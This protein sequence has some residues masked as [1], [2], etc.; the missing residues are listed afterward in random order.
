LAKK[1]K[2]KICL[3]ASSGGHLTE[4]LK[5]S[6]SWKQYETFFVTT[7]PVVRDNLQTSGNIYIVGECNRQ[8]L[9]R[10]LKVFLRCLRI[11]LKERPN[12]VISTGAAAGCIICFLAKLSGAEIIWIDSITNVEK[13]SLSGRMVRYIAD[14]FLVQWPELTKKYNNVEFIG[15]VI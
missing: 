14:L 7:V 13:I 3:A 1:N 6:D 4:L 8:H 10:V 9:I 11:A 12:V 5:L 2:L 15:A